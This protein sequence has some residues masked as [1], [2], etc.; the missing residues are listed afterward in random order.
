MWLAV[1][2]SLSNMVP[3]TIEDYTGV[4]GIHDAWRIQKNWQVLRAICVFFVSI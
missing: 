1:E 4:R 3:G 2:A